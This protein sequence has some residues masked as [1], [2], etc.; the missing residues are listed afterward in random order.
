M[1]C[2]GR[3]DFGPVEFENFVEENF[4]QNSGFPAHPQD[5][6]A[7]IPVNSDGN[8][9]DPEAWASTE[10]GEHEPHRQQTRAIPVNVSSPNAIDVASFLGTDI[11][12]TIFY[13]PLPE[14]GAASIFRLDSTA[15]D[16]RQQGHASPTRVAKVGA[17]WCITCCRFPA[18][19]AILH[20]SS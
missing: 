10:S 9:S 5:N 7:E 11:D 19:T 3:A 6:N 2:R 14:N 16:H 17:T 8:A 4:S 15:L 12:C 13:H 1:D 18:L 20:V